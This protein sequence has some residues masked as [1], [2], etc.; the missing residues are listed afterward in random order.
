MF[1]HRFRLH[2][3][4]DLELCI[5]Y[6]NF[7]VQ[8]QADKDLVQ[9][10]NLQVVIVEPDELLVQS[11]DHDEIPVN[12]SAKSEHLGH[13]DVFLEYL[14]PERS[15]ACTCDLDLLLELDVDLF[16]L[17]DLLQLAVDFEVRRIEFPAI[18]LLFALFVIF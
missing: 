18:I 17:N 15:G 12:L 6:L 10:R 13:I 4:N 1:L 8:Y 9:I 3:L 16:E 5:L 2:Y 14:L 11:L 7:K